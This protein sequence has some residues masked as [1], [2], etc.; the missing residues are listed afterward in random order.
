MVYICAAYDSPAAL[1]ILLEA[2]ASP[3]LVGGTWCTPLQAALAMGNRSIALKLLEHGARADI[4]GGD[5]DSPL[6]AAV[7]RVANL[8]TELVQKL[9]DAGADVTR[10]AGPDAS[11][12]HSSTAI[13]LA[14]YYS[15]EEVVKLLIDKGADVNTRGCWA[16]DNCLQAASHRGHV[17]IVKLLLEAG[18]DKTHAGAGEY[19]SCLSAATSPGHAE[20]VQLL[21]DSGVSVDIR[22]SLNAYSI[23]DSA[24]LNHPEITKI[25]LKAGASPDSKTDDDVG[26]CL[27]LAASWGHTE[28]IKV[29]LEG[30]G[31][32]N[33]ET[34]ELRYPLTVACQKV[35]DGS[36]D[37]L[38]EDLLKHGADPNLVSNSGQ[39]EGVL[40]LMYSVQIST[41]RLLLDH[42]ADINGQS[43]QYT[44]PLTQAITKQRLEILEY[45]LERGADVQE[46]HPITGLPLSY[47]SAFENTDIVKKLLEKA[48]INANDN[49]NGTALHMAAFWGKEDS[50]DALLA[51]GADETIVYWLR[52]PVFMAA[53]YTQDLD[54]VK[55]LGEKLKSRQ[56]TNMIG[57]NA[58][59]VAIMKKNW[60]IAW[61]LLK[62]GFSM[63]S[64]DK[65]GCNGLHYA[66]RHAHIRLIRHAITKDGVDVNSI[67]NN[68]WTALHCAAVSSLDT[69]RV[70]KILLTLGC[71]TSIK[72]KQGRTAADLAVGF[73][74]AQEAALLRHG[75]SI[76]SSLKIIPAAA[77]TSPPWG[78]GYCDACG[79]STGNCHHCQQCP[80][81]DLCFR[82]YLNRDEVH[83]PDHELPLKSP[84]DD[85]VEYGLDEA[86]IPA[87]PDD[88]T[89][90]TVFVYDSTQE[91]RSLTIK[92]GTYT[93]GMWLSAR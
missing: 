27:Y 50:I 57:H 49:K 54:F 43:K 79:N 28:V 14:S 88:A 52:G 55:K 19:G 53:C 85:L 30:G 56:G 10:Q 38:I 41:A 47:A 39:H 66:A 87:V 7:M 63:A 81:F 46:Y 68:S 76:S 83:F 90:P 31:D 75:L 84:N 25:L 34:G 89:A 26:C 4:Y 37:D 40:P 69:A 91:D 32:P 1:D 93:L 59:H 58:L 36:L 72:D 77:R 80:D 33:Q 9:I 92:A 82:C 44:A 23:C 67:D 42:G 29:L 20:V 12:V 65:F 78:S 22:S 51:A 3:N 15:D 24:V 13:Y 18:A 6:L 73:G 5:Y 16:Y 2:G 64:T 8:D 62:N 11:E 86:W 60:G 70:I 48:D 35:D 74:K 61:H 71:D 45:F 17:G 21:V